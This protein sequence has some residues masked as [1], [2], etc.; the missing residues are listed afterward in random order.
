MVLFLLRPAPRPGEWRVT[1]ARGAMLRDGDG[2]PALL[3]PGSFV[4]SV[5]ISVAAGGEVRLTQPP[6]TV[7]LTAESETQVTGGALQIERGSLRLEGRD[8]R[9][10]INGT[11][12][13]A[14]GPSAAIAVAAKRRSEMIPIRATSLTKPILATAAATMV[15]VTVYQ[16]TAR[17]Q[18]AGAPAPVTMAQDDRLLL[19]PRQPPLLT[20]RRPIVD[21]NTVN[22]SDEAALRRQIRAALDSS[23]VLRCY[24]LALDQQPMSDGRVVVQMRIAKQGENG[25]VASAEIIRDDSTL[26]A[27][28]TQ[29]C[30]LEAL[31]RLE[32][33]APKGTLIV[34][35]PFIFKKEAKPEDD[36][37]GLR[38]PFDGEPKRST[39]PIPEDKER[40]KLLMPKF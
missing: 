36:S 20:H 17:V 29:Q 21:V 2:P 32:L 34:T 16:G 26:N 27:P 15:V 23:D 9:V 33:P 31:S 30:I 11:T 35:Y 24:Q 5:H 12:V 37:Q 1:A 14:V 8:A 18:P 10:V 39:Q 3:L 7:T 40:M 4:N 6:A 13:T 38:S 19:E 25:V 22:E 28:V